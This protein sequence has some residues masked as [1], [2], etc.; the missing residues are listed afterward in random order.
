MIKAIVTMT[1]LGTLVGA[2]GCAVEGEEEIRMTSAYLTG[3]DCFTNSGINPMKAA[4]AVSMAGEMG[5][6]DAAVDLRAVNGVVAVSDTGLA[7]CA[8]R[9]VTG[10]PNT[11][12]ILGMQSTSV[13][14]FISQTTFNA[15][16]FRQDLKA[17]F[18]RQRA[19][20]NNLRMNRPA[21]LPREH[22]LTETSMTDFGA[23]GIHYDFLAQGEQIANIE[24]RLVFFGGDNNP[25][26]DFRST[27]TTISIDPTG[28][29][30]GDTAT[31][32]GSCTLGCFAYSTSLTNTCC[33]CNAKQGL[34]KV[35]P[36]DRRMLY[37]AM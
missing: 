9:G 19:H 29:M 6:L 12:S 32:S 13:N 18:D 25:F 21:R 15:V 8:A 36:W 30:N 17:S 23:C 28:T 34:Y 1:V 33:S 5:R 37:C 22:T 3:A 10:C 11:T 14:G 26:L 31:A 27:D 24:E 20:E 2:T 16:S 4:L 7:R 35:A